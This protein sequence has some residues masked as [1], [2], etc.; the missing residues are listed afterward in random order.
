MLFDTERVAAFCEACC[1]T[2]GPFLSALAHPHT[3]LW[4][5]PWALKGSPVKSFLLTVTLFLC[6]AEAAH[7]IIEPPAEYDRPYP[8][9]TRIQE[10]PMDRMHQVCR[11]LAGKDIAKNVLACGKVR[12]GKC[13]VRIPNRAELARRNFSEEKRD[14]LIRH[15]RA[16][17]FGWIHPRPPNAVME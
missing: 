16:H 5:R 7:A 11:T 9:G 1:L 10:F 17:C 13:I 3:K 14:L 15:E 8:G 6:L 2:S 12:K 4:R